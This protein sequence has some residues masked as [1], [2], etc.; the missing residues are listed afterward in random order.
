MNIQIILSNLTLF[1]LTGS[2]VIGTSG[3]PELFLLLD[4]LYTYDG[5]LVAMEANLI[6]A[7]VFFPDGL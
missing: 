6:L 1:L 7:G 2:G 5:M 4:S 3:L